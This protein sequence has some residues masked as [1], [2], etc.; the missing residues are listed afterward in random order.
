MITNLV[1][2]TGPSSY[3]SG[4]IILALNHRAILCRHAEEICYE[5]EEKNK[6]LIL[7]N[8]GFVA[9]DSKLKDFFETLYEYKYERVGR[10]EFIITRL[11][12]GATSLVLPGD[13]TLFNNPFSG[14]TESILLVEFLQRRL[15]TL[16]EPNSAGLPIFG[17]DGNEFW[18]GGDIDTSTEKIERVWDA[19]ESKSD[20]LRSDHSHWPSCPEDHRGNLFIA[21][22]DIPD[23]AA[24]RLELPL[25]DYTDKENPV[26][27]KKREH[28]V[29]W[30]A[31]LG[32]TGREIEKALDPNDLFDLREE[33]LVVKEEAINAIY[34]KSIEGIESKATVDVLD[35]KEVIIKDAEIKEDIIKGIK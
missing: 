3:E 13:G 21:V 28:K 29:D 5:R 26:I 8:E 30:I 23:K 10:R 7:N 20:K 11:S 9:S 15:N 2:R 32:L 24:V 6:R 33:K 18:F 22:E 17:E 14:N 1:L 34:V 35:D 25:Y 16:R 31:E 12:D 27:F 4:D 19:I